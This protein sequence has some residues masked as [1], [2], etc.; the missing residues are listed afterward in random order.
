MRVA[1]TGASAGVGA[2]IDGGTE[3]EGATRAVVMGPKAGAKEVVKAGVGVVRCVCTGAEVKPETGCKALGCGCVGG[4]T[5]AE[6]DVG[7][8]ATAEACAGS[9]TVLVDTWFCM[10]AAAWVG[11]RPMAGVATG[12]CDVVA[13]AEVCTAGTG[14]G[15]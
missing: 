2:S 11:T 15:I 9:A 6:T 4:T 10:A 12:S 7:A 1:E 14:V 3:A 5:C 8:A 13:G